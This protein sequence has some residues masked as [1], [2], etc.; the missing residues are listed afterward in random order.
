[1]DAILPHEHCDSLV[2][3]RA[4]AN[5]GLASGGIFAYRPGLEVQSTE[6]G[7]VAAVSVVFGLGVVWAGY[8]LPEDSTTYVWGY[9]Y[10]LMPFQ[11][12]V[13]L[14]DEW[15]HLRFNFSYLIFYVC[16]AVRIPDFL[17]SVLLHYFHNMQQYVGDHY[18]YPSAVRGLKFALV[19]VYI[20]FVRRW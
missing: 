6:A 8:L 9:V 17:G 10:L 3:V 15:K 14:M 13:V 12:G 5:D 19:V 7:F 11:L 18:H 4:R 1:M 20:V 16:V 2:Q